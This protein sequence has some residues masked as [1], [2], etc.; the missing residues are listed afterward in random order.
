[1]IKD[2]KSYIKHYSSVLSTEVCDQTL[3]DLQRANW[4]QH[5]FYNSFKK[6]YYVNESE[7]EVTYEGITTDKII[8][9]VVWKQLEQYIIKDLNLSWWSSW[10]GI[11]PI[12]FNRY[13]NYSSMTEHCD[14]IHD[15][16]DGTKKGI[17][18]LTVIGLLNSEYT[19]GEFIILED[20]V[21]NLQKGDIV[22]FPSLFLYPHK[23]S[24]VTS[25]VRYSFATWIW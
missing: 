8:M 10:Q 6:E 15:M 16:F 13:S 18:I 17:P 24:P 20:D 21:I 7:P 5:T 22:I 4:K 23:V 12:K 19:G 3:T 9:D 2:L 1:M 14:H 25:G 11:N